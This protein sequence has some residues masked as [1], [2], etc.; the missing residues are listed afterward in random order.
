[1]KRRNFIKTTGLGIAALTVVGN[2]I[3]ANNE[4]NKTKLNIVVL[5]SGGVNFNDIIS[6][7]NKQLLCF[8][9]NFSGKIICHTHLKYSG[10]NLEH[11]QAL[12]NALQSFK[13]NSHKQIFI[14]SENSETTEHVLNSNI[15]F[16]ILHVKTLNIDKPNNAD[17]AVF[18]KAFENFTPA[19]DTTVILNLE[20]TDVAHYN[21]EK[22]KEVL[23]FYSE[24]ITKI[25]EFIFND[26]TSQ[27]YEPTLT[28]FSVL[29]RNC[30]SNE[31]GSTNMAFSSD[32]YDESA[33]DLFCLS[34][35]KS[36][37][38]MILFDDTAIDS[39]EFFKSIPVVSV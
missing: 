33:R 20:D 14:S 17:A 24:Q 26:Y 39:S 32:H 22:Y 15:P 19:N 36:N 2:K 35:Q 5:L 4:F 11:A 23:S 34:Y 30:F 31:I 16:D 25:A 28:V 1:M 3:Y 29:G 27:K 18:E 6:K 21:S 12:L 10:K 38:K 13:G 7:K 37:H 8:E 9:N